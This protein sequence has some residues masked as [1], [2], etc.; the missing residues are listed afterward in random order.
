MVNCMKSRNKY[1]NFCLFII[2]LF[3]NT[4]AINL[5]YIPNNIVS[6]GSSGL[7]ILIN[8]FIDIPI[9]L[10]VLCISSFLLLVG[11]MVFGVEYGVR[12]LLGT[13]LFPLFL[14][15]TSVFKNIIVFDN[16]SLFLLTLVGSCLNGFG[17][18]LI[19][20][21]GYS[22]GGFFV[23][24]DIIRS[25]FKI[26]VGKASLICNSFIIILSIIVFGGD[27][28]IYSL[29]AI[30]ISTYIGDRVM[31]GIS[32]N[33]AFYV[34]TDKANMI[35]DYIIDNLHYTVTVINAKGGY[36]NKKKK[37]ILC[38]IPTMKY[39]IVKEVIRE[40]DKNAFILITDSYSVSK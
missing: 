31:I 17:F 30:Y 1:F 10:I 39:N 32:R 11:F 37:I 18:G 40:I 5:F 4:L 9:P 34:I 12:T 27:R 38:V 29:I 6:T 14:G 25:V 26:S 36:S 3:I 22:M 19:K 2:G 33:K 35:S 8:Y 13:I 28:C 16:S 7:A 24:Y 21:S 15:I 23:L 20:K